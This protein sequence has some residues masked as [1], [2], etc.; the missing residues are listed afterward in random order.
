MGVRDG[1]VLPLHGCRESFEDLEVAAEGVGGVEKFRV[2]GLEF[3][4]QR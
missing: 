3:R 1:V 2:E 4:V